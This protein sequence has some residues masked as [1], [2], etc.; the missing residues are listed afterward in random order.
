MASELIRKQTPEERELAKKR[1]ELADLEARLLQRELELS[2]LQAELQAFEAR[3]IRV[4]GTRY[5]ELDEIEARI[6]EAE[7]RNRPHDQEAQHKAAEARERWKESARAT[8]DAFARDQKPFVPTDDLRA[9]FREVVKR[10]HL[11]LT[12][13]EHER[14][15]RHVLM[16][17]ANLAYAE[18]DIA[19]LRELLRDAEL[20]PDAVV[21]DG[22]GVEL[23][24]VIRKIAQVEER[25][26]RIDAEIEALKKSNL[27]EL[28]AKAE[29][30]EK[31][32]KDLLA[33]MAASIGARIANARERLNRVMS[34]S[35]P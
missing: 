32:G 30:A 22:P 17:Q 5:A 33:E 14:A 9:L 24:R 35:M 27:W 10:L 18:G 3:Y 20:N 25:L 13:D 6:A 16:T 19:K 21:G 1:K 26:E 23:V 2:T 29:V 7:A 12:T 28:R 11:D 34:Q 4:V 31:E 8:E 15:R